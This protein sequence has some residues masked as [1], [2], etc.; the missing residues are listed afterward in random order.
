MEDVQ[1]YLKSSKVEEGDY[2]EV[3]EYGIK[4]GFN[5]ND[6]YSKHNNLENYD[7]YNLNLDEV[8]LIRIGNSSS[9]YGGKIELGKEY[10]IR[11]VKK[12]KISPGWIYLKEFKDFSGEWHPGGFEIKTDLRLVKIKSRDSLAVIDFK[13]NIIYENKDYKSIFPN[14]EKNR[15]FN[16]IKV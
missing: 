6:Y 4:K 1:D 2:L 12:G 8:K 16:I 15:L 5:G 13:K 11:G 10:T 3:K 7:R 9:F 14:E